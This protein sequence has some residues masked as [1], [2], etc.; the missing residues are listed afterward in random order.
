M[1][2]YMYTTDSEVLMMN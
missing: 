2:S 1:T